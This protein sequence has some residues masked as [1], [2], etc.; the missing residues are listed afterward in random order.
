MIKLSFRAQV[1]S[2]FIVS[3]ILVLTVGMLSYKS[4]S[5]FR[6]DSVWVEHTQKVIKTSNNLLQLMIDAETGM[7]GYAATENPD[8]LDPYNTAIPK[9]TTD[10]NQLKELVQDN[11]LEVRRIDSVSALVH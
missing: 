7:R 6:D 9:I 4:I 1:L 8:F 3:I 5:Q 11:P 10:I 2:G